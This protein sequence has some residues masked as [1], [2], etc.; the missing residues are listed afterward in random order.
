MAVKHEKKSRELLV[1]ESVTL[2]HPLI[3]IKTVSY[4]IVDVVSLWTARKRW[5]RSIVLMVKT[6]NIHTTLSLLVLATVVI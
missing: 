2:M 5:F 6:K 4:Q 3:S 1:E